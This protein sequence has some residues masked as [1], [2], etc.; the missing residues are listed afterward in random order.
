MLDEAE[1]QRG[2]A[3]PRCLTGSHPTAACAADSRAASGDEHWMEL[4][5]QN[6]N[7]GLMELT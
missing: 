3:R 2:Q 4:Q 6:A 7:A 5:G 1:G